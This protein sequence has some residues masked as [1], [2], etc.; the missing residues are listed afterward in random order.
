VDTGRGMVR[1]ITG[2]MVA[3]PLR[4]YREALKHGG[5]PTYK[6]QTCK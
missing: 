3:G 1:G 5:E 6:G 2:G 4:D